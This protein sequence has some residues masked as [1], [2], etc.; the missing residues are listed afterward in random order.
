[1]DVIKDTDLEL[2]AAVVEKRE[3]A[4][5]VKEETVHAIDLKSTGVFEISWTRDFSVFLL[6]FPF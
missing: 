1:M 6:K 3:M 4:G 5:T 2:A